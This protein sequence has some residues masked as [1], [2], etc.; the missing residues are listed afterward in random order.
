MAVTKRAPGAGRP[1]K[2]TSIV[3]LEGGRQ[4]KKPKNEPLPLVTYK[5]PPGNLNTKAKEKWEE[6]GPKLY[7]LGLLTELD[8]DSFEA[9][10]ITYAK[11]KEA[12]EKATVGVI[13]APSG[14]VQINPMISVAR[15]YFTQ[16]KALLIE[17]GMSP[18]A[19]T[20]IEAMPASGEQI[21][22]EELLSGPRLVKK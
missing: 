17:F 13:Q 1:R 2:P 5:R 7:K 11:W 16:Y 12:E 3:K 19:R 18:A 22:L 10:C 6:L 9:L 15:G 8:L 14:Y 4:V 20:K 21:P